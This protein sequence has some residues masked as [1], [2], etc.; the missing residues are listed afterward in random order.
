M[1]GGHRLARTL[2]G[3]PRSDQGVGEEKR[4]QRKKGVVGGST[5]ATGVEDQLTN[6]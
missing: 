3:Q 4:V 2:G 1:G 5:G 6:S